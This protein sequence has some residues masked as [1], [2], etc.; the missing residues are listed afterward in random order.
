MSD[1]TAGYYS[2]NARTFYDATVNLDMGAHYRPFLELIPEGG[3]ILDA[4]CGSG[5]DSLHF[6]QKGY[7]VVAFDYAEPLVRLASELI[8]EPVMHLSFAEVEFDSEFDGVWACGSLLH[9][10]R[11]DLQG[12]LKRLFRAL[13]PAGML[14][15]SFKWGE[16]EEVRGGRLFSDYTEDTFRTLVAPL[17]MVET[18]RFRRT[19]D[20]RP[21]RRGEYWLG[22]LLRKTR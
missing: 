8:G 21:R 16:N 13:K 3:R 18:I 12:I 7:A 2:E 20:V 5:R 9:V 10:P 22:V 14:Y 15:A 4:G 1:P 17:N 19:E 11:D 6:K